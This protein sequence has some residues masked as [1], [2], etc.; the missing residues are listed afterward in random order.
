MFSGYTRKASAL[1][2]IASV[3]ANSDAEANFA[4]LDSADS[5]FYFNLM[6][7]N[8]MVVGTSEMYRST[9]NRAIGIFSVQRNAPRAPIVDL[10]IGVAKPTSP[11]ANF[12]LYQVITIFFCFCY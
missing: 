6:A 3:R 7:Q 9:A 12:E 10:T 11:K 4:K 5:Q 1:K 8:N 2:G